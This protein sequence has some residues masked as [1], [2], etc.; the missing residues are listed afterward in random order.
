MAGLGAALGASGEAKVWA[1]GFGIVFH[2]GR[3]SERFMACIKYFH[4]GYTLLA[5]VGK[6]LALT[7]KLVFTI[8]F[9]S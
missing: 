2:L 6:V 9:F 1:S 4:L 8:I 3:S 5:Y 7:G